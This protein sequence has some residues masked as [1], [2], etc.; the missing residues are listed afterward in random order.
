MRTA[1]RFTRLRRLHRFDHAPGVDKAHL[2]VNGT[3]AAVKYNERRHA[4]HVEAHDTLTP[5]F[6]QGVHTNHLRLPVQL[7]FEPVHDGLC[8]EAG[9]SSIAVELDHDRLAGLDD[10]RPSTAGC[11]RLL[12]A[13]QHERDGDHREH[14]DQGAILNDKL[15]DWRHTPR[16]SVYTLCA[17]ISSSML[18]YRLTFHTSPSEQEH[19]V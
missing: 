12:R 18:Q 16:L 19:R 2:P 11:L 7:P 4:A 9:R 3:P 8:Q 5:Q 15:D 17:S 6:A 1:S 10:P 14:D 13:Q